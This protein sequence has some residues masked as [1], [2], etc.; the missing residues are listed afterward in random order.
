MMAKHKV[1]V[2]MASF[3]GIAWLPDQIKSILSQSNVEISLFISDDFSQ[4]GSYKYL[5]QSAL[6]DKRIR[7]LP[8]TEKFGSA[9]NNFYRL[10]QDVN[11]THYDYVAFADQDDFWEQGKL[12]RHIELIQKHSADGVSSN[13]IAFWADGDK[14]FI[15]KSQPQ[16]NWDFLFE[17]AGPGCTFLMTPWLINKVREQL[18]NPQSLARQVVL[19]DWLTYAICR[20]H[21]YKWVIDSTP[22]MMYRQHT[23][24]V[25]GANSGIKAKLSRLKKISDG[26]YRA[27]VTK[28]V[29][30]CM[31]I[32][33]D[34]ELNKISKYL[35]RDDW[36]GKIGLL[37][38][39]SKARRSFKDRVFLTISVLFGV[40]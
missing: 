3:N 9:G 17:S 26:W 13:V 30:V 27:E 8:Q 21:G 23:N 18:M 7:L 12:I 19:H 2:L 38:F 20:A 39:M 31:T 15:T 4:D 11:I 35:E 34:S 33:N 24:N 40:F 22:S 5:Q 10:I 37:R 6:S 29:Q 16:K 1:A 25:V 14:K 32:S 36:V 28:I